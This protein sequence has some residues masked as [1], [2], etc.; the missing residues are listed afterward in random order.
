MYIVQ[1][2]IDKQMWEA[3]QRNEEAQKK[4]RKKEGGKYE[5]WSYY[6]HSFNISYVNKNT[7]FSFFQSLSIFI[8]FFII[9]VK[10]I[11]H[12]IDIFL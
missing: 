11:W 3:D 12:L 4:Q 9:S 1:L 10:E 2:Y 5:Y 8:L 6:F 7:F